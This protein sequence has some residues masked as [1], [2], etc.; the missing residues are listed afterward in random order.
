MSGPWRFRLARFSLLKR[1]RI[2]AC[3]PNLNEGLK[4]I[5]EG[6]FGFRFSPAKQEKLTLCQEAFNL[7]M[8]KVGKVW[9]REKEQREI[10]ERLL[11]EVEEAVAVTDEAGKVTTAN[12]V[13][14]RLLA[15]VRPEGKYIGE[16][17]RSTPFQDYFSRLKNSS[18]RA[19]SEEEIKLGERFY[20]VKAIG[21]GV[22]QA[23]SKRIA[24]IMRDISRE[25]NLEVIKKE[26]VGNISHELRTPLTSIKGYLETLQEEE[27]SKAAR[28]YLQTIKN[29][30][31]RLERIVVD[32]LTLS[33]LENRQEAREKEE[34]DLRE[35]VRRV[36][37]QMEPFARRKGLSFRLEAGSEVPPLCGDQFQL[38]QMLVNLVDNAVKYTDRGTVTIR[39]IK[40]EDEVVI[41]VEDTG[42]GIPASHL[43]RIFERFY[44]V[45]RSRAR[46][47]GGT[48]LGLSIVKHIV[49]LHGGKINVKSQEGVG[50][51]FTI[52]FP[53]K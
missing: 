37:S 48:G 43:E 35:L 46:R 31:E 40:K 19:L 51:T 25:K 24:I 47:L 1:R 52:S 41:E 53:Q 34:V 38:E 13:L 5:E 12:K 45:D 17:I 22:Y 11:S 30:V 28:A 3:L 42:I 20:A 7:I 6:D 32:L 9:R 2:E 4:R 18:E 10:F 29:N 36:F 44:V 14:R 50:T 27:M 16:V 15:P 26:L 8:D 21:G 23:E 49:L 33:A 39:L